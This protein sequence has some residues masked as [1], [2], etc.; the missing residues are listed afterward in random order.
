[1]HGV[2]I[3]GA[4]NRPDQIDSVLLRPGRLDQL[5]HS[6]P[7]KPSWLSIPCFKK[8]P[9][10]LQIYDHVIINA[11]SAFN[12]R[13]SFP[14]ITTTT[15]GF[16]GPT[17]KEHWIAPQPTIRAST[18]IAKITPLLDLSLVFPSK[19]GS[20][21]STTISA[22]TENGVFHKIKYQEHLLYDVLVSKLLAASTITGAAGPT[23]STVP[24][25]GAKLKAAPPKSVHHHRRRRAIDKTMPG[26][27][28]FA[29][30]SSPQYP[31]PASRTSPGGSMYLLPPPTRL[32]R[33][34]APTL[35]LPANAVCMYPTPLLPG[36][37]SRNPRSISGG[38]KP[39]VHPFLL[40]GELS[41]FAGPNVLRN[42]TG[43]LQVILNYNRN[44]ERRRLERHEGDNADEEEDDETRFIDFSL[45]YHVSVQLRDK[46]PC[47][48][49]V[50]GSIPYP[51]VHVVVRR[52]FLA[53]LRAKN[54]I[55]S[56]AVPDDNSI[57]I[58]RDLE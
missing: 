54:D 58:R 47:G 5:L 14:Q 25:N 10:L 17:S 23:T 56:L 29:L 24:E 46:V 45:L 55:R 36:N 44:A 7:D 1:M 34:G 13:L 39:P 6:P 40:F 20:K 11:S 38:S 37:G 53:S 49:H 9:V 18:F 19:N 43:L 33:L 12:T 51:R 30:F 3:I 42:P 22:V 35:P 52:V 28:P 27:P 48:T 31:A 32:P 16:E 26:Q 21:A 50:K 15:S 4:M 57:L 41:N 2:F 8:S